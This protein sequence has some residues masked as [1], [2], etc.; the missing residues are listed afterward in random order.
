MVSPSINRRKNQEGSR[1]FPLRLHLAFPLVTRRCAAVIVEVSLVAAS[2]LVPLSIGLYAKDHSRA[3]PVP[4]N[5]VLA[6]TEEAIAKT[7]GQ[8]RDQLTSE[9]A[10]LTNLFWCGALVMPAVVIGRQLYL[11]GK[12]GKT[13]PKRWFGVQ[14]VTAYGHPP[15]LIR[16]IWREAVGRWGVPMGT[17]YLLWRYT[18][19]FPDVG[20][21]L[22]LAGLMLLAESSCYLFNSRRRTLHDQ[23]AGT[24]VLDARNNFSSYPNS[25]QTGRSLGRDQTVTLDM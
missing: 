19:A 9:V 15:G 22:G 11:L 12:T 21:L 4:L 16:A 7:L 8:P 18:G 1:L 5:P 2:A 3:E 20:I 25:V 13:T 10:P 6:A 14:V 24:Y 17:A 23:L